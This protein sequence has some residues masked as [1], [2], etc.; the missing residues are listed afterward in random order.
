MT[1]LASW[2]LV[3]YCSGQGLWAKPHSTSLWG[4]HHGAHQ[5]WMLIT[6]GHFSMIRSIFISNT[7]C[8][9]LAPNDILFNWYLLLCVLITSSLLLAAVMWTWRKAF[10]AS[11]LVK[12]TAPASW[13]QFSSTVLGLWF[14]LIMAL[15]SSLSLRQGLTSPNGFTG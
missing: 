13:W 9:I 6:P 5:K 4:W 15:F 10:R 7:S 8:D 12:T 1:L 2:V 11:A 14:C 3:S